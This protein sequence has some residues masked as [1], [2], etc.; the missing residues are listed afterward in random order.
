MENEQKMKALMKSRK[1]KMANSSNVT[2]TK[3]NAK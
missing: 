2:V 1:E 3:Q